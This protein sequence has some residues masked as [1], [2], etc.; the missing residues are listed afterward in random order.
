MLVT[1]RHQAPRHRSLRG[2][3][4]IPKWRFPKIGG[5]QNWWFIL[6]HPTKMD[7]LRV[8]LFHTI[9]FLAATTKLV[10]PPISGN[11]HINPYPSQFCGTMRPHVFPQLQKNRV[12]TASP[13]RS[14]KQRDNSIFGQKNITSHKL[15]YCPA[16]HAFSFVFL[17]ISLKK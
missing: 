6:E 10:N 13:K 16:F 1:W 3:N 12:T 7:D 17:F 11:P 15:S 14:G 8:P 2:W 4:L 5:I 9:D